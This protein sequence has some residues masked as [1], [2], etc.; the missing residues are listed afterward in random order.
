MHPQTHRHCN[1]LHSP[2]LILPLKALYPRLYLTQYLSPI[3]SSMLFP[4]CALRYPRGHP[5]M[6]RLLPFLGSDPTPPLRLPC[7]DTRVSSCPSGFCRPLSGM[8]LYALRCAPSRRIRTY[9]GIMMSCVLSGLFIPSLPISCS[10][11]G[12][13]GPHQ[14]V[15]CKL[16]FDPLL[17]SSQSPHPPSDLLLCENKNSRYSMV[18]SNGPP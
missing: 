5:Y 6:P 2:P 16:H 17:P 1:G 18:A 15:V 9:Y 7:P 13:G 14:S 10:P 3:E 12:T 11:F 8:F 4:E